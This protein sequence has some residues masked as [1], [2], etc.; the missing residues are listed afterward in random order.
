MI[1]SVADVTSI[2]LVSGLVE[3]VSAVDILLV[4]NPAGITISSS[5]TRNMRTIMN[6]LM[7]L[8]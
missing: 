5:N 1:V 2:V 8:I 7:G 3:I 6:G 4:D